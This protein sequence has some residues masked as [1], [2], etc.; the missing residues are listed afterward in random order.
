MNTSCK[1]YLLQ[2][3]SNA[4]INEALSSLDGMLVHGRYYVDFVHYKFRHRELETNFSKGLFSPDEYHK[5]RAKFMNGLIA[6]AN[7]LDEQELIPQILLLSPT[8]AAHNEIAERF[9]RYFPNTAEEFEG[10]LLDNSFAFVVCN[11][12]NTPQD[13]QERFD[14]LMQDYLNKGYLLVCASKSNQ[15]AIVSNNR[16]KVHA[17]NSP[18]AL[19]AR[20]RE[21]IDYVRYFR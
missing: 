18:F 2:L 20:V 13:Q 12:F 16:D 1:T 4:S 6:F 11:D 15:K 7:E 19:F 10:K 14:K 21:M 8:Q 17:A 9:K 5:E 3:L